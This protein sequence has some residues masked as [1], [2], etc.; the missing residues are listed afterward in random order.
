MR[1]APTVLVID[2]DPNIRALLKDY[3]SEAGYQAAVASDGRMGL[4]MAKAINPYAITLDVLMPE[5]DG[6]E[7]L[8]QLKMAPVTRDIPVIMISVTEDHA[9]SAALGASGYLAKPVDR[10]LLLRELKHLS[11]TRKVRRVLV[12]DDDLSMQ[13]M[14]ENLLSEAGYEVSIA[15]G[16]EAG[17]ELASQDMPDAMI[18]DLVMPDLDGFEVLE[19]LRKNHPTRELPVI[20]L[21]SKDLKQEEKLILA[22]TVKRTILKGSLDQHHLV[23]EVGSALRQIE[24]SRPAQGVKKLS[25]MVVEDNKV[26]SSQIKRLL[27]EAGFGATVAHDGV[28]ALECI[29]RVRPDGIILDLMMPDLDGFEV[30]DRM[31]SESWSRELP[32]LVLTAKELTRQ[33]RTRLATT[34]C[35]SWCKRAISNPAN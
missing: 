22:K 9:T 26:A 1:Q 24:Q 14:M 18:L 35:M 34:T 5:L 30:L 3:L 10:Q 33:D 8:R 16:G 20:V 2:D 12:V 19:R 25:L 27:E 21:T 28:Q 11:M 32:V 13:A 29:S 6:W 17:V 7:V 15:G 31:R 4:R 23:A